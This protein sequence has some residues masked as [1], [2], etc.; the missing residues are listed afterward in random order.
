M[1]GPLSIDR[2]PRRVLVTGGGGFIGRHALPDL[3]ARGWEV[4]A[5]GRSPLPSEMA[6]GVVFH[7]CD[8]LAEGDAARVVE[9]V[10]P[11][12]LLH[13]AWNAVPGRFWTAPDNLDWVAASLRLYRAFAACGGKRAVL[14]GTCAEYDW[15]HAELSE[16]TT[17]LAP[18]TLYGQAKNAFRTL[19]EGT[20][21]ALGVEVAWGRIFFLYGPHEAPSRFVP[22]V[23]TSLLKGE[24]ALC[25]HGR[26]ER[27]FMHVAD[28]ARA[29]VALL[30]SNHTGPVN[31][32]SG[33]A[34]PLS[35][36]VDVIARLIGRP[37]LVRLGARPAPAGDPP[38]LAAAVG[39]LRDQ[40]GFHP[41][42]DLESGLRDAV[43]WWRP[44]C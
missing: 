23:I 20:A 8:L 37:D 12:H 41:R 31:I 1:T 7:L 29:F 40:V 27:D 39:V 25:S 4:H 18:H 17:P 35:T 16:A 19:A 14:A 42:F 33:T 15:S 34:L 44:R 26:Q 10:R 21:G 43:E 28:V 32:A 38:R 30:E 24:P 2:R 36:V 11:T 3:V 5:A 9:T 13:L 6:A 22:D